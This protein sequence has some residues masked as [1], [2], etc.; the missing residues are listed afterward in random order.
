MPQED[1]V[2]EIT[3]EMLLGL[4]DPVAV[5]EET[6]P[7]E[8]PVVE[9][10]APVESAVTEETPA[11]PEP[12][13]VHKVKVRR[14]VQDSTPAVQPDALADEVVRRIEAKQQAAKPAPT[15]EPEEDLS[16]LVEGEIA[17]INL[18]K[19]VEGKDPK[20]AGLAKK[21]T[22]F[23]KAN[24]AK[25][26]E[27][28][29]KAEENGE[30]FDSSTDAEYRKWF[31]KNQV[32]LSSAEVDHWKLARVKEEAIA[33][34]ESRHKGELAEVNRRLREV[35]VRP[36]VAQA[37]SEF[38]NLVI[39]DAPADVLKYFEDNGRDEAKLAE[40]YPLE[41]AIIR[42]AVVETGKWVEEL[43]LI[44]AGAKV[45]DIKN[46]KVHAQLE[47]VASMASTRLLKAGGAA[48][49][50]QGKKFVAPDKY[51]RDPNTWTIGPGEIKQEIRRL[52]KQYVADKIKETEEQN[53]KLGFTRAPR[54][55]QKTT[56]TLA[57]PSTRTVAEPPVRTEAAPVKVGGVTGKKNIYDELLGF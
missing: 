19:Y 30:V 15:P 56:E 14:A 28:A 5:V 31:K 17:R 23:F 45:P 47:Q 39:K 3:F 27:L 13:K 11:A 37:V 22:A 8:T 7:V 51:T 18:Y 25:L 12:V 44:Y 1:P 36:K 53:K 48:L 32:G 2:K 42:D 21:A 16:D 50:R 54:S 29:A 40:Q 55:V 57:T 52:T 34:A 24:A 10:V 4:S 35:D 38:Q 33:E 43:E 6:P 49:V 26:A 9:P 20:Q 46:N 41:H